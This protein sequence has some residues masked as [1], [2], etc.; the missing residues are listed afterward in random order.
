MEYFAI[1]RNIPYLEKLVDLESKSNNKENR[2]WSKA[3]G[4]VLTFLKKSLPLDEQLEKIENYA[5]S[6]KIPAIVKKII[7]VYVC[8]DAKQYT[9]LFETAKKVVPCISEIKNQLL[10]EF[11]SVR[12]SEILSNAYLYAKAD[13]KK[14]RFYAR[15]VINSKYVCAKFKINLYYIMGMSFLFESYDNFREKM[16]E[17]V[18]QLKQQRL[19]RT[20]DYIKNNDFVFA[21][22][23]WD[24]K[25]GIEEQSDMLESAYYYAKNGQTAR[26]LH[27][28]DDYKDKEDPFYLCYRGIAENDPNKL[29][30]A[31]IELENK[32][33]KFF[34]Q[35]PLN[36]LRKNA[37]Y[38]NVAEVIFNTIKIA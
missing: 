16:N 1:T 15:N 25:E 28:L 22:V 36:E 33:N 38:S 29:V 27:L 5:P 26:A 9:R 11:F 17:Y 31:M 13:T 14:A 32:G 37:S 19:L 30:K 8:H 35:L 3:Y 7:T 6:Y 34:A 21:N 10:R 12:L 20:I 23:Y 4:L 18:E 2:D 24:R